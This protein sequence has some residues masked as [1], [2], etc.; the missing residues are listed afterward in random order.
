MKTAANGLRPTFDHHVARH[1]TLRVLL[2]DFIPERDGKEDRDENRENGRDPPEIFELLARER[3]CPFRKESVVQPTGNL[4]PDQHTK[5]VRDHKNQ[6]LSLAADGGSC[7]FVHVDLTR[8]EEEVEANAVEG[9]TQKDHPENP[10]FS[11]PGKQRV[12]Q[13]PRRHTYH[14]HPLHAQAGEKDRHEKHE[15]KLGHLADRDR[16]STRLNSSHV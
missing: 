3:I 1:L 2:I 13:E 5:T 9:N 16:K 7:L 12:T 15:E 10:R 14:E 6:P 8:D 11:R 4:R